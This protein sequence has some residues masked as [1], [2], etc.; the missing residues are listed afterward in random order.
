LGIRL[1]GFRRLGSFDLTHPYIV[2]FMDLKFGD[3]IPLDE[4][5]VTPDMIFYSDKLVTVYEN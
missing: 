4:P 5:V 1:S 3:N 2:K